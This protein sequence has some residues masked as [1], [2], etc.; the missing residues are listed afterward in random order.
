M[1]LER[2]AGDGICEFNGQRK[3]KS[4]HFTRREERKALNVSVH[5]Q[6]QMVYFSG[7]GTGGANGTSPPVFGISY[8]S[9]SKGGV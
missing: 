3:E 8:S 1:H 6:T 9:L 2:A 4:L 7:D 5:A